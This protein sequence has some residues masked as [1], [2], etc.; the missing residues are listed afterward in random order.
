MAKY[1]F[2]NKLNDCLERLLSGTETIEQCLQRY[3]NEAK[4]LE[5]LLRTAMS[6][7]KA[8]DITPTPESKSRIRYNLQL[9]MAEVGKPRRA[10]WIS[11][12]PRWAMAMMA[13]MLVFVVGGGAVLA[14]DSSMPG[15]LLYPIKILTEN[16]SLKLAASDIEKAE[17]SLTFA[18]R[19]VE[20]MNYL[21]ERDK[22]DETHMESIADR[23]IGYLDQVS[24]FSYG[25]RDVSEKGMVL[26][27]APATA[28]TNEESTTEPGE[29]EKATASP[30]A[31]QVTL[32]IPSDETGVSSLEAQAYVEQD[33]LS[34]MIAYYVYHHP[35]KLDKWLEDP[36]IPEEYKI[37]MR[38]M[39]QNMKNLRHY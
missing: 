15:S 39:I 23:Y 28:P 33:K 32:E 35:Q 30:P 8:V 21:M 4:E 1:E 13:V 31:P 7:D 3:P 6:V 27:T 12:Q 19:R 38:R 18:D 36:N 10:S 25:T 2:E 26:M 24:L 20:E 34:Q 5:P 37:L 22:L 11:L 9:K 17:L 14:A 16:I 29:G